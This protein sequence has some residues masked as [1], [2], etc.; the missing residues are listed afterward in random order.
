MKF[1]VHKVSVKKRG[2]KVILTAYGRTAKGVGFVINSHEIVTT[3]LS[4]SQLDSAMLAEIE[5]FVPSIPLIP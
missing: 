5:K 4:K 3:G 2:D 1:N